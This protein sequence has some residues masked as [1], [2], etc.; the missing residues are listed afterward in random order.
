MSPAFPFGKGDA[1]W[2]IV[3][4]ETRNGKIINPPKREWIEDIVKKC[5]AKKVP[6]FMK[7]NLQDIWQEPLP[8]EFPWEVPS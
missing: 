4:A 3:G 8:Q 6:V 2:V 5:K 1:D 7:N